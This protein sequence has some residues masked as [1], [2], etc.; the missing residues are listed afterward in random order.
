RARRRR[1]LLRL[2][3]TLELPLPPRKRPCADPFARRERLRAEPAP[4][5]SRHH[6]RPLC[7]S[8]LAPFM[9]RG[10]YGGPDPSA[11]TW[12]TGRLPSVAV[13]GGALLCHYSL[14]LHVMPL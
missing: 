2:R 5:V 10:S 1:H 4:L 3:I 13:L 7:S 6:L 9:G 14:T 8:H 12:F 11:V